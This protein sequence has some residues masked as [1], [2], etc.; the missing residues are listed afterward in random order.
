MNNGGQKM[1]VF[2]ILTPYNYSQQSCVVADSIGEAEKLFLQ[3]YPNS[4]ILKIEKHSD[5]V[6]VKN[7]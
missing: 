2:N 3:K 5:Y 6:I 7:T 1:K 4:T